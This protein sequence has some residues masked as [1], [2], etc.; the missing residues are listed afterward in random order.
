MGKDIVTFAAIIGA[1][2][3]LFYIYPQQISA[4]TGMS[5]GTVIILLLVGYAI[6]TSRKGH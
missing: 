5:T 6:F 2:I 3:A 4:A 1:L